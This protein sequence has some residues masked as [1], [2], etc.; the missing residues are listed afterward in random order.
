M[1]ATQTM[2]APRANR[3][4]SIPVRTIGDEDLAKHQGVP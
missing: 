2:S 1:A 4:K 3:S